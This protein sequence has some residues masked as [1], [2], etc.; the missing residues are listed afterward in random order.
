MDYTTSRLIMGITLLLMIFDLDN[1]IEYLN[2]GPVSIA[3]FPFALWLSVFLHELG[4]VI[5][6][7]L[8]F[9]KVCKLCVGS[10][11]A[12][13]VSN[14]IELRIDPTGGYVS[15]VA[16]TKLQNIVITV[17]GPAMNIALIL[18]VPTTNLF[19]Q[20]FFYTNTMCLLFALSSNE[21]SDLSILKELLNGN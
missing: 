10:G 17:A 5:G 3:Y 4:H 21:D 12:I 7:L 1:A 16:K 2:F 19:L 20:T 11:T 9:A 6:A 18:L 13:I 15:H 14:K 8:S